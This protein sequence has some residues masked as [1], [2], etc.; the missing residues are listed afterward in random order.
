ME[1]KASSALAHL[2]IGV[3]HEVGETEDGETFIAMADYEGETLGQR[4]ELGPDLQ[5]S[6]EVTGISFCSRGRATRDLVERRYRR[7]P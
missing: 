6:P 4:L 3:I 7:H 5:R 1:A 2:N